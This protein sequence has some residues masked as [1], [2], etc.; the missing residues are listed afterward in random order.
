MH[1][2]FSDVAPT[3]DFFDVVEIT[4]KDEVPGCEVGF[5]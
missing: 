5:A 2:P 3:V 1:L 4:S